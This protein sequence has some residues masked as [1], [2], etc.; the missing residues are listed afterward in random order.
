MEPKLTEILDAEF[1]PPITKPEDLY[2]AETKETA[3][4]L[5]KA[6]Q[7][8]LQR[9]APTYTLPPPAESKDPRSLMRRIGDSIVCALLPTT[10]TTQILQRIEEDKLLADAKAKYEW[11]T[12]SVPIV[13]QAIKAFN[14]SYTNIASF[15]YTMRTGI[16]RMEERIGA[17]QATIGHN[18]EEMTKLKNDIESGTMHK[19]LEELLKDGITQQAIAI[20]KTE[21][22]K[23]KKAVAQTKRDNEYAQEL[24][25]YHERLLPACERSLKDIERAIKLAQEQKMDLGLTLTTYQGIT[26]NQISTIEAEQIIQATQTTSD[27]LKGDMK[28]I[29]ALLAE[30]V[31]MLE[32]TA[33]NPRQLPV[34]DPESI[35]IMAELEE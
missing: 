14:D 8:E 3:L 21:I 2:N 10:K 28:Q 35:N 7:Q 15:L 5:A 1:V 9:E 11:L 12:N 31:E 18:L 34:A 30:K 29:D 25:D 23:C 13:E 6:G 22:S 17:G 19:E 32:L 33:P 24:I 4:A 26:K 20:L 27:R 16:E